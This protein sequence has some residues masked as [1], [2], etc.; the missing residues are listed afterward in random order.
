MLDLAHHES[1]STSVAYSSRFLSLRRA[2]PGRLFDW[3]IMVIPRTATKSHHSR[4]TPVVIHA[5]PV[6]SPRCPADPPDRPAGTPRAREKKSP[7]PSPNR[8]ELAVDRS[9]SPMVPAFILGTDLSS[10][11]TEQ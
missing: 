4:P 10:Y 2:W 1:S 5:A 6:A 9:S 8:G 7:R 11:M 3:P